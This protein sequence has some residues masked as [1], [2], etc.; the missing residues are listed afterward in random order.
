MSNYTVRINFNDGTYDYDFPQA[1]SVADPKEGMKATVIQGARGDGSI[2]IPGGKKSQTI[3]VNGKLWAEDY[4]ALI[5]LINTL[6]SSI[7]TDIATLKM[8]HLDPGEVVDWSYTVRRIGEIIFP[9]SLRTS[10]QEYT[11]SFLVVS[12]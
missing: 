3:V 8:T 9:S 2:I 10:T 11:I 7:T 5:S 6:K 1:Q 12:Y 4:K